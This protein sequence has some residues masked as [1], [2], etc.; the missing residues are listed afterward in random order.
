MKTI[1]IITQKGGT[2]KATIALNLGVAAERSGRQSAVIYIDPKASEK[3][4]HDLR[5]SDFAVVVNSWGAFMKSLNCDELSFCQINTRAHA[6]R[7]GF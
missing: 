7:H 6:D 3:Y 4:W 1:A 2:G 5:G